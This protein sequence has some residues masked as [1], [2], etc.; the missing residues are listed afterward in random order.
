[1][2]NVAEQDQNKNLPDFPYSPAELRRISAAVQAEGYPPVGRTG[3]A[4]ALQEVRR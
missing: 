2:K 3:V 4:A 1:V